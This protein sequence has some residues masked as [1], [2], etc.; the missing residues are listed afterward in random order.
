MLAA[1]ETEHDVFAYVQLFLGP[2]CIPDSYYVMLGTIDS[3]RAPMSFVFGHAYVYH[4]TQ[5]EA[6]SAGKVS[7][8]TV[9]P[10]PTQQ[11]RAAGYFPTSAE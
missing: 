10:V 3:P 6:G 9:T 1:D 5:P 4:E 11:V 8:M 2:G 7:A